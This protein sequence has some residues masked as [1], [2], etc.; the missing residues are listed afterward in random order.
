MRERA[1]S[2]LARRHFPLLA[3]LLLVV[4]IGL[5]AERW[6]CAGSG[7]GLL[8]LR[9]PTMGTRYSLKVVAE[10]GDPA[11]ERRIA[12]AVEA[13]L[14]RIVAL[15]S[16]WDPES[17]LSRFNRSAAGAPFPVS[18]ETLEVFGAARQVSA[19]SKGAFDVTVGPLV[20]AW[21]FGPAERLPE[22]PG[23]AVLRR[24]RERV[25][26]RRV[27]IDEDR[28]AL[29][30]RRDDVVCDLS[31]L[32]K[33][34]AVDRVAGALRALGHRDFLVEVGGELRAEGLRPDGEPWRVAIEAPVRAR[35][36][37][38]GT[39]ALSGRAMATSGDYRNYYE[40][41]GVWLSHLIDPRTGHPISHSLAS[42]SV[43]HPQGVLADAW[44]TALLVLGPEEGYATAEREGLA[45]HFIERTPDGGL[46]ARATPGFP[47]LR[48]DT[49]WPGSGAAVTPGAAGPSP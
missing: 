44:A 24:L 12:A 31:A 46:R 26:Y 3:S 47:P 1:P 20:D 9:G 29:V 38:Y 36:A 13:E 23:E 14:A 40:A 37:P 11:R 22:P 27:E 35:R 5:V 43:V 7:S 45:A 4:G 30:K 49:P 19:R 8:E 34:Y 33:G 28:G 6:V 39:V 25:G 16:T 32:A 10:P 18:P 48:I 21:G 17:E 15:M 42:V 2:G 41:D